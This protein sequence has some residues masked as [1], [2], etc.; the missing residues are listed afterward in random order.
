LSYLTLCPKNKRSMV[1]GVEDMGAMAYGDMKI[2][3]INNNDL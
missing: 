2:V 1:M 3:V